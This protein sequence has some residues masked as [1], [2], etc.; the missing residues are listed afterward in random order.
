VTFS[1]RA[2]QVVT[3][4]KLK[5][6]YAYSPALIP[7]LSHIN[8]MVNEQV[9]ATIPVPTEQAGRTCSARSSSRRA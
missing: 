9:A 4:A 5:I 8:V 2:D 1:I 3:S 6:N 7:Q